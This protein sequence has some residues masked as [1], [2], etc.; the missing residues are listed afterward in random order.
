MTTIKRGTIRG[1][2]AAEHR[3]SVQVTG[4]LAVYLPAVPVAT[5]V[6]SAAV[7]AGRECGVVFFTD[8]D[9][10]DAVVV[11]IHG[12]SPPPAFGSR[13]QDADADTSWD[14]EASADEDRLRCT[15]AGTLRTLVQ[16]ASPHFQIT[17]DLKVSGKIIGEGVSG[18]A[19]NLADVG[20]GATY[21][22]RMGVHIGLGANQSVTSGNV[23]GLGGYALAKTAGDS[24][25]LGLDFT[26]GSQNIDLAAAYGVRTTCFS[27]GAGKTVSAY[28]GHF[29]QSPTILFAT[30]TNLIQAYFPGPI[31]GTNR[32]H[33]KM[34]DI[35]GG[36][37][38]RLL[39]LANALIVKGSGEYTKASN[40]TP[41]FIYEGATD[42]AAVGAGDRVMVLV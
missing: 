39:D 4:S 41:V 36:T 5:D 14:S 17:G 31:Y 18:A 38:A 3:A 42:G 22:Q 27:I 6:P 24:A 21:T 35:A 25:A 37:I 26:T 12:A 40:Q 11:T 16:N 28:Y 7:V 15:V 1:Y 20:G 2:D 33:I 23:V 19:N 10:A 32:Y 8:D 30:L 29:F 13:I 9:P 34:E